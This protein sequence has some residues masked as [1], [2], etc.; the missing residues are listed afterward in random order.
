MC[1]S[2]QCL[3]GSDCTSQGHFWHQR[4]TSGIQIDHASAMTQLSKLYKTSN[5]QCPNYTHNKGNVLM[6]VSSCIP[7]GHSIWNET[8]PLKKNKAFCRHIQENVFF[9]RVPS[10]SSHC[11][12]P[13][14][15]FPWAHGKVRGTFIAEIMSAHRKHQ[16]GTDCP[17][18]CLELEYVR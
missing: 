10:W 12:L 11:S 7:R 6:N 8:A 9:L 17:A 18:V 1:F 15:T 3:C 16:I 13:C 2:W 4:L 14:K 5:T